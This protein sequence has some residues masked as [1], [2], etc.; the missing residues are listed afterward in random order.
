M[1]RNKLQARGPRAGGASIWP[2]PAYWEQG[3]HVG[4]GARG[5]PRAHGDRP[6]M[7]TRGG[8]HAAGRFNAP[9]SRCPSDRLRSS[10]ALHVAMR[11]SPSIVL[12]DDPSFVAAPQR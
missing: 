10:P 11:S 4:L 9:H 2:I 5:P 7:P 3:V 8:G 12:A 1:K 6:V